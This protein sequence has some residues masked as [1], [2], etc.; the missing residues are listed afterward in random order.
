MTIL[1]VFHPWRDTKMRDNLTKIKDLARDVEQWDKNMKL[2][3]FCITSLA[4]EIE[5]LKKEVNEKRKL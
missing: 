3:V 5:E 2:L 4:D 1:W